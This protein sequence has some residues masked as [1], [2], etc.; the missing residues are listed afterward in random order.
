VQYS[1]RSLKKTPNLTE[2]AQLEL[3]QIDQG[4]QDQLYLNWLMFVMDPRGML[5]EGFSSIENPDEVALGMK[6]QIVNSMFRRL[7][8]L[9]VGTG[10]LNQAGINGTVYPINFT[11]EK[12]GNL[13]KITNRSENSKNMGAIRSKAPTKKT[14]AINTEAPI[15][16]NH[17][18]ETVWSWNPSL[19]LP[20]AQRGILRLVILYYGKVVSL[21]GVDLDTKWAKAIKSGFRS[22]D[23][24]VFK[25][26]IDLKKVLAKNSNQKA[27]KFKKREGAVTEEIFNKL[28]HVGKPS[29]SEDDRRRI[30]IIVAESNSS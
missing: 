18:E 9:E 1:L 14:G 23:E 7:P 22:G 13:L 15:N 25:F 29:L 3:G 2:A 12:E 19:S 6:V 11:V 24:K 21:F 4:K 8:K 26:P 20:E 17:S 5:L 30:A 28:N 16:I 10:V 27:T